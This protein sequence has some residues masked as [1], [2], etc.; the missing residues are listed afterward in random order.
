MKIPKIV[1]KN[2]KRYKFE[3]LYSDYALYSEEVYGYKECFKFH[4]LGLIK[5][6]NLEREAS[7]GGT[8]KI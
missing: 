1:I 2:N 5:E 6:T 8:V 3:K 4:D 7:K